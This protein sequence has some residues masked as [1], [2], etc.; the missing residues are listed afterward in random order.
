MCALI[1][2]L[3]HSPVDAS[4]VETHNIWSWSSAK[5]H[6]NFMNLSSLP[7]IQAKLSHSVCTHFKPLILLNLCTYFSSL[8]IFSYTH[9]EEIS[10]RSVYHIH[11]PQVFVL[12]SHFK[13]TSSDGVPEWPGFTSAPRAQESLPLTKGTAEAA[14]LSI[15]CPAFRSIFLIPPIPS[16]S[17]SFSNRR[18]LI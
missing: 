14:V 9:Y 2:R 13:H 12:L 17:R 15:F 8:L 4:P 3:S 11:F 6:F 18:H 10:K 1:C 7:L 5:W 16:V